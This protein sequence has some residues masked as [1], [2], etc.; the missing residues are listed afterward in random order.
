MLKMHF[1]LIAISA[2]KYSALK[3]ANKHNIKMQSSVH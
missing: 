3:T 1:N 2:R